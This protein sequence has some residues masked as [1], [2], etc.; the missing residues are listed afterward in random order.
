MHFDQLQCTLNTI[1]IIITTGIHILI[2]LNHEMSDTYT[3]QFLADQSMN[4]RCISM[5]KCCI[6]PKKIRL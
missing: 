2:R 6:T 1:K 3:E 5:N 4:Q